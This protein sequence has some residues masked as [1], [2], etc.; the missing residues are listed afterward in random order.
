M[1]GLPGAAEPQT[2]ISAAPQCRAA[3]DRPDVQLKDFFE[4]VILG[5]GFRF[6]RLYEK[7]IYS[8]KVPYSMI[9]GFRKT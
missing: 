3:R 6:C 8:E 7:R 5:L 9:K 4:A 1:K 2:V